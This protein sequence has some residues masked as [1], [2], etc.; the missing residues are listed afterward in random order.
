MRRP[1]PLSLKVKSK[2]AELYLLPKKDVFSIAKNYNN[3]WSKIHKKDFH[4]MVSIKHQTFNILN[5]YI[6]INGIGKINPNDMSRYIYAW[7]DPAKNQILQNKEKKANKS[8]IRKYLTPNLTP[9]NRNINNN[10]N[11]NNNNDNSYNNIINNNIIRDSINSNNIKDNSINDNISSNINKTIEKASPKSQTN[12]PVQTD[13]GFSQFLTL[14]TNNMQIRNTNNSI[15]KTNNITF[16]SAKNIIINNNKNELNLYLNTM[17]LKESSGTVRSNIYNDKNQTNRTNEEGKTNLMPKDSGTL[18]PSTLNTIFDEKKAKEIKEQIDKSKKK[19]IFRKVLSFGKKV[20]ELFTNE[21]YHVFLIDKKDNLVQLE[22]KNFFNSKYL[23]KDNDIFKDCKFFLEKIQDISFEE[24]N[25][26]HFNEKNLTKEG[27][28][29][30]S[31]ESIYQN[32]NIITNMKYSKNKNYQEKTIKFLKK[33]KDKKHSS[34]SSGENKNSFS[35]SFSD[36]HNPNSI[37]SLSK[38]NNKESLNISAKNSK[39]IDL[40]NLFSDS[41]KDNNPKS[42]QLYKKKKHRQK[43]KDKDK[44]DV[45]QKFTIGNSVFSRGDLGTNINIHEYQS[46]KPAQAINLET[47]KKNSVKRSK[48][49]KNFKTNTK[50]TFKIDTV[51]ANNSGINDIK[52]IVLYQ[53]KRRKAGLRKEKVIRQ[54]VKKAIYFFPLKMQ[55][56]LNLL[57]LQKKNI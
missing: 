55:A 19:E 41:T 40:S 50:Y 8:P 26:K 17:Q 22:N 49:S 7:E 3:I 31:F 36:E 9:I 32:I 11:N 5:K 39:I 28:I 56:I 33:L 25:F 45:A 48:I 38:N 46:L 44:I 21:K 51:D 10:D 34:I 6:E 43:N 37:Y 14:T 2:F 53:R 1:S 16:K 54:V 4:N 57:K 15:N 12:L 47:P 27:V 24:E 23:I 42:V 35:N 20:A 18:L 30:F 52:P 29:S 13:V